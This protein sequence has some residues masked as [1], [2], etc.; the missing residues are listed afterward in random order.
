MVQKEVDLVLK[1]NCMTTEK[2]IQDQ[3]AGD[4]NR[5]WNSIYDGK[6]PEGLISKFREALMFHTALSLQAHQSVMRELLETKDY[7]LKFLHV[8]VILN[9]LFSV[10]FNAIFFSPEEAMDSI[11][12]YKEIE[13]E[14]NK[15]VE[16]RSK[17]LEAKRQ[18][19][20]TLSGVVKSVNFNNHQKN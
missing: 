9:T 4:Y 19:L 15:R 11:I 5:F 17:E 14:F 3:L 2:D 8:G 16:K 18:R 13:I 10:P 7:D 6:I 1:I 12:E 20:L